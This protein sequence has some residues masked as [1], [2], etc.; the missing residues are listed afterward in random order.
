VLHGVGIY[1]ITSSARSSSDGEL[2]MT[3]LFAP[4]NSTAGS[5]TEGAQAGFNSPDGVAAER[6]H[7]PTE[8]TIG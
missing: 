2:A 8:A 6:S 5:H 1:W 3:D 4:V 7:R